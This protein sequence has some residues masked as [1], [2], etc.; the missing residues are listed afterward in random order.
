MKTSGSRGTVLTLLTLSVIGCLGSP[1][2]VDPQQTLPFTV[3]LVPVK[4]SPQEPG[5]QE[6]VT[7]ADF[8]EPEKLTLD[9]AR[10]LDE[11]GIFSSVVTDEEPDVP[12]DLELHMS[13]RDLDFGKGD[14][15]IGGAI[16]S[17]ITWI[18]AGHLSWFIDNRIYPNSRV[19]ISIRIYESGE[20]GQGSLFEDLLPLKGLQLNFMERTAAAGWFLNVFIPPWVGDGDPNAC[21][22]SLA[23]RSARFF[24]D[25]ETAQILYGLPEKYFERKNCFFGYDAAAEELVIV[26]RVAVDSVTIRGAESAGH[27][28]HDA[29]TNLKLTADRA[30][31]LRLWFRERVSGLNIEPSDLYYRIRLTQ[32]A[33]SVYRVAGRLTDGTSLSATVR[34]PPGDAS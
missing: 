18:A 8:G 29:L 5:R 31:E 15:T 26:S 32:R 24:A 34:I 28:D 10:V 14:V 7:P 25:Q 27:L 30:N 19:S 9:F 13:I 33:S 3:R 12:A 21:G 11:A 23:A 22:S 20:D 2:R 16:V 1:E 6:I 17:T 4:I